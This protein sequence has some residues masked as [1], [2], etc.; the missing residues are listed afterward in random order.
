ME[1]MAKHGGLGMAA[2]QAGMDRK[3]A[4]KYV[5]E[6]KFP[7]G[8]EQE[9]TWRTRE[10]PFEEQWASLAERLKEA[11]KLETKTL[12]EE[13]GRRARHVRSAGADALSGCSRPQGCPRTRHSPRSSRRSRRPRCAVSY[14]S[15]AR[16]ASS[17]ARRTCWPSDCRGEARRTVSA[18]GHELVRRGYEVLLVPVV[19]LEQRLL[20]A[21]KSLLL[22]KE[23]RRLDGYD[24]VIID[25]IGYIQQDREEMEVLFTFLAQRHE[26]RSVLITSNLVECPTSFST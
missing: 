25:D 11:P 2:A 22:T 3:T 24:A 16:A 19:L 7:S 1:E 26:R 14:R 21:K 8:L 17:S 18:I 10:D 6:G 13:P 12:F 5:K 23:L 15:Y 20:L 4:R 9:R